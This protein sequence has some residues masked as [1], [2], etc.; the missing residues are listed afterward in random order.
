MDQ[1]RSRLKSGKKVRTAL[2]REVDQEL[3]SK[4]KDVLKDFDES[5][6]LYVPAKRRK[7]PIGTGGQ[8]G[9]AD[10]LI[11]RLEMEPIRSVFRKEAHEFTKWLES[12]IEVLARRLGMELTVIQREKDVG[13]FSVDLLC[14]DANERPVIVENQLEKTDHDHLGKLLTYLVNLDAATAIWVTPEPRPEHQR[15][16]DWLNEST[17]A[18]ISFYLVKVEAVRIEG[19][20]YAPLFTV[21]AGP[22]K[23]AKEIGEKK[24]EWAERHYQRF[25]FWKGLLD[26]CKGKTRLFSNTSPGR[27]HWIGT[28]AGKS[29]VGLNL[30]I[31]KDWGQVETYIDHG[32]SEENKSIF[33]ALHTQ[34]EAV[35]KDFGEPLAWERLEDKRAC[36]IHKRFTSGGLASPETW[37]TL[38]EQMIDAADRLDR[39]IRSRLTKIDT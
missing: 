29:G 7:E 3:I 11:G 21:L 26:R 30:V 9:S 28:G 35:E 16:I 31:T 8:M 38:Q 2:D 5:Q 22:D 15:V 19:S 20:P 14:E 24:K 39:A 6:A 37:P 27:Y 17:P 34:R 10:E 25:E 36:R 1:V 18:D 13:D 32:T 12:H 33:D 23:Q 4:G